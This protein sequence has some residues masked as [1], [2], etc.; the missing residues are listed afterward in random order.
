F[1]ID[2]R[3]PAERDA[4]DEN[5]VE[6]RKELSGSQQTHDFSGRRPSVARD[7]SDDETFESC[8]CADRS[9]HGHLRATGVTKGRAVETNGS[10]QLF[11]GRKSHPFELIFSARGRTRATS[12]S[13]TPTGG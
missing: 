6:L 9:H 7:A 3:E 2:E 8:P 5:D 12:Q 13:V 4:V 10:H 11:I 1:E